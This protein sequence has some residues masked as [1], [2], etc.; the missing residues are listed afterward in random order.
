LTPSATIYAPA[1]T[2]WDILGNGLA[3]AYLV[4]GLILLVALVRAV[5]HF[6]EVMSGRQPIEIQA[7]T[8]RSSV[9]AET[10][11]RLRAR[12]AALD[13]RSARSAANRAA[14]GTVFEKKSAPVA[15]INME[16]FFRP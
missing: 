8:V 13:H 15:G 10:A 5:W 9:D 7:R 11:R 16:S 2:V 6:G 3:I 1:Y 14:K 4:M 12:G